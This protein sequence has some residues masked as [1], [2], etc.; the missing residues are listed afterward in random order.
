MPRL[1]LPSY[2]PPSF[3][4]FT[5]FGLLPHPLAAA[6]APTGTS[7]RAAAASQAAIRGDTP[8][9]Y[10]RVRRI[11]SHGRLAHP[12]FLAYAGMTVSRA[13]AAMTTCFL[14]ACALCLAAPAAMALTPS[15]TTKRS[16]Y[17]KHATFVVVYQGYG[18]WSTTYHATPPNPG[19]APDTNDAHDASAQRWNLVFRQRV[20]VDPCG[21]GKDG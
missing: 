19:G 9:P 4:A 3:G 21:P 17:L 20:A 1:W 7:T 2:W 11:A 5:G 12:E 13:A 14:A 15:Y 18:I 6:G 10:K 16:A 8:S